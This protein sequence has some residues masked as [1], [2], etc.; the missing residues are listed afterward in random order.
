MAPSSTQM[1]KSESCQ[2]SLT[3]PSPSS[4]STNQNPHP[5]D[6]T[7]CK[8][9]WATCFQLPPNTQGWATSGSACSPNLG[10]Y[11]QLELSLKIQIIPCCIP[12]PYHKIQFNTLWWATMG[13]DLIEKAQSPSLCQHPS[14]T[15]SMLLLLSAP[16]PLT[17]SFGSTHAISL[18]A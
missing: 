14:L 5:V 7:S 3:L 11:L 17:F 16:A 13:L 15:S 1:L 18:S 8:H 2:L 10:P 6:S 12:S 9:I 4:L